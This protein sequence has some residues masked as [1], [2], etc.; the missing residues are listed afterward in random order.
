MRFGTGNALRLALLASALAGATAVPASAS[1]SAATSTALE[2]VDGPGSFAVA[3][4][5]I[6]TLTGAPEPNR[7]GADL[8]PATGRL[9][10]TSPEG[11]MAPATPRG[12]CR[13]D[14][15]T[16]VSCEPG[17]VDAIGGDLGGGA[18]SFTAGPGLPVVIGLNLEGTERPLLGGSGRDRLIGGAADDLIL[19]GAGADLL[20]GTDGTDI[21]R[22]EGGADKLKGGPAPDLLSGGA[23]DDRLNGGSG[24]DRCLGGGGRD[25]GFGCAESNGIP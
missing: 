9:L 18:D 22:G 15:A 10:L 11:I 1:A 3:P 16:Q 4:L 17:Y 2:R 25:R 23:G 20:N 24:R 12:E 21:L 8:D 13:Q 14:A 19:G 6:F 5:D 7:I